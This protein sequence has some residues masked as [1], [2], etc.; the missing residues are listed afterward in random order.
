MSN[1]FASPIGLLVGRKI[2]KSM[3]RSFGTSGACTFMFYPPGVPNGTTKDLPKS[4][5][6]L[7][8]KLNT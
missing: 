7:H 2:P 1:Y 6:E 8:S 3:K 4:N 5:S